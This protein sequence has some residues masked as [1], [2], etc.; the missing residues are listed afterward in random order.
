[1]EQEGQYV[2]AAREHNLVLAEVGVW[3]NLL[4]RDPQT[5]AQNLC[6]AIARLETA[7]R[8]GARCC[9]NITG[10]C[11]D[12]WDGPHPMNYAEET[13]QEI[14]RITREILR[15]VRPTR[16]YY[17]L[18]CMPWAYPWDTASMERLVD[19][20]DHPAFAV[21]VDMVN[22]VN[23]M[24]KVYHTGAL[25]QAF[26]DRFGPMIRSVHA[27]DF[28]LLDKLT[29]HIEEALPGAGQFDLDTLL[30]ACAA[31]DDVPVMAEHLS[32]EAAYDQAIAALRGRAE[33][34]GIPF[35]LPT[36]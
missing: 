9:V 34:L 20:V 23:A 3:N 24:D 1:L 31:L 36:A 17:T 8:I 14:V 35:D 11:S 22:M 6:H 29:L 28:V 30:R 18:E 27:K 32:G 12:R 7:E 19:A 10:S 26:F 5:R 33:T 25:T 13:F 21:H 15:A 2:A 16:T 4:A